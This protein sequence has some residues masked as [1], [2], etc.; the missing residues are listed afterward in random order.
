MASTATNSDYK[1][2]SEELANLRADMSRLAESVQG[3]ANHAAND[4]GRRL[5]DGWA[6]GKK[7]AVE[8]EQQVEMQISTHPLQSVGIAFGVG[9]LIG[10]L[11]SRG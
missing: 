5:K 9:F 2:V 1:Q 6:E 4:A 8:A 11:A 10:K 7:R 3:A